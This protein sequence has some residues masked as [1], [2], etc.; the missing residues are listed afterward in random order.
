MR[1]IF[2]AFRDFL[3]ALKEHALLG[4]LTADGE[5]CLITQAWRILNVPYYT[6]L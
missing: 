5:Y 1:S 3:L 6:D 2:R 4:A